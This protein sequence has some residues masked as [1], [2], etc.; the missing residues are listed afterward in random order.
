MLGA[1]STLVAVVLGVWVWAR[2]DELASRRVLFASYATG[3]AAVVGVACLAMAALVSL[4][5][6]GTAR[7]KR[8]D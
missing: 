8:L 2:A 3:S 7:H 5:D 6:W 1:G 4:T